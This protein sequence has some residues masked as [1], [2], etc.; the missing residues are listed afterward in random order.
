MWS[1]W[2][3]VANWNYKIQPSSFRKRRLWAK[4]EFLW[5]K[6]MHHGRRELDEVEADAPPRRV[7][8]GRGIGG[9]QA[10]RRRSALTLC[11]SGRSSCTPPLSC[12]SY[13]RRRCYSSRRCSLRHSRRR[14]RR[15]RTR[16]RL[17]PSYPE[18]EC[19]TVLFT[20]QPGVPDRLVGALN[21][22][23]TAAATRF[24]ALLSDL[25]TWAHT[26]TSRAES[27]KLGP[28]GE[29]PEQPTD[30]GGGESGD[31][32]AANRLLVVGRHGGHVERLALSESSESSWDYAA[33]AIAS[34]CKREGILRCHSRGNHHL[35]SRG[36]SGAVCGHRDDVV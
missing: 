18:G 32:A 12:R 19:H 30:S 3:E 14:R 28:R 1:Q 10:G 4:S 5:S 27:P 11:R 15:R 6:K 24:S 22:L 13:R 23:P 8:T 35:L 16:K 33:A 9:R 29:S 21:K 34:C 36:A 2:V 7:G 31:C 26:Q 20:S 25:L 17:W